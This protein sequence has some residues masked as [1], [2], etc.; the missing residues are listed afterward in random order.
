MYLN[1]VVYV[2]H[3]L[4]SVKRL[5]VETVSKIHYIV[6]GGAQFNSTQVVHP[7]IKSDTVVNNYDRNVGAV[8]VCFA[9]NASRPLALR[10]CSHSFP[11]NTPS[12]DL[13][14]IHTLKSSFFTYLKWWT[15]EN[16]EQQQTANAE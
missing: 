13:N 10:L 7:Y 9:G 6:T 8:T 4:S 15:S 16:G 12:S 11:P 1:V 3:L 5:D 2:F 14:P